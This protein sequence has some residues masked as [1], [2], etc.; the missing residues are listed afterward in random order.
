MNP[1]M[2]TRSDSR[3]P[4]HKMQ[5]HNV[6]EMV[7]THYNNTVNWTHLSIVIPINITLI[8]SQHSIDIVQP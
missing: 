5:V 3:V 4:N 6:G 7:H 2:N 1:C 8:I